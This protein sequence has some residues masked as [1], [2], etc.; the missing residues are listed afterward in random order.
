[1]LYA[2]RRCCVAIALSVLTF[3][4]HSADTPYD[5]FQA[6]ACQAV[7]SLLLYRGEGTQAKHAERLQQDL[8]TLSTQ[9]AGLPSS[10]SKL[11]SKHAEL[12]RLLRQ[13]LTFGPSEEDM[14][15]AYPEDLAEALR[16]TLLATI[17][18]SGGEAVNGLS[19]RIEYLT[20][21]YLYRAYFGLFEA[22]RERPDLYLGQTDTVLIASIEEALTD[23]AKNPQLQDGKAQARWK[24]LKVAL[25]DMNSDDGAVMVGTRSGRPYAPLIVD[26]HS[27]ALT[28]RIAQLQ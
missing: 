25:S 19:Q 6:E 12:E 15:W 7:N 11:A 18:A 13:G 10:T 9:L 26:R 2:V 24:F 21:Q 14:P 23:K 16:Q 27:R 17:E 1:M 28:E 20:V 4:A 5:L 22:L 8:Q 3:A